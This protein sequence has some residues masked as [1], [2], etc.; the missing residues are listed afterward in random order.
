M[1]N[2]KI[3]ILRPFGPS[4]FKIT[5]P[6]DI[7]AVLNNHVDKIILDE[8]MSKSLDHG[9][10]LAGNVK[11][12]FRL[13]NEFLKSSGFLNFLVAST[14]R[15]M[16]L[17]EG[18]KISEFNILA[19]WIVRQFKNEYN[20]IH[21][22]GG[23]ISGVGYL[24]VPENFGQTFQK[25]KNSNLNGSLALIHGARMF[26]CGST[27]NVTPK[28]G[29]FYFFPN[30]LLHM[31]YPFFDSNEERRSISFNARIDE[32]IYNVYNRKG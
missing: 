22:H 27:F 8:E 12:E 31:V 11:Q 18:K 16:E 15:W 29:D 1:E 3:E 14:S 20:P 7:I 23:H 28:V 30:Y 6:K 25:N 4:I 26:N 17:T 19:S 2:H 32:Q 9:I 21:F 24:K 10:N 13:E 5:M